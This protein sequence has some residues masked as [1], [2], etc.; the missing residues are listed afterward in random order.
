MKAKLSPEQAKANRRASCRKWQRKNLA[1]AAAYAR[2]HRK[3]DPVARA[4]HAERT[5]QWRMNNPEKYRVQL[6]RRKLTYRADPSK[7]RD[8]LLVRK[9]GITLDRYFEM[10]AEQDGRCKLCHEPFGESKAKRPALDHDHK[11]GKVRGILHTN[12][13]IAIGMLEDNQK[14]CMQ[15][16]EY[17]RSFQ[18]EESGT[19]LKVV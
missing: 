9:Y 3:K 6:D 18:G 5:R 19:L 13:N 7:H 16:A 10:I 11:D 12:C 1:K 17:L 15:A 14:M 4:K 2:E 8:Y